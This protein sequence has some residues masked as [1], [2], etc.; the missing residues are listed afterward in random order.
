VKSFGVIWDH[1]ESFKSW[2]DKIS[3]TI[4]CNAAQKC[5]FLFL[6]IG[7]TDVGD[8]ERENLNQLGSQFT[9]ACRAVAEIRP[10]SNISAV[11]ISYKDD[12]LT[13]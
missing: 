7:T 2:G 3:Y 8:S 5:T 1:L 10:S 11:S 13:K 4:K 6:S 9:K 12:E